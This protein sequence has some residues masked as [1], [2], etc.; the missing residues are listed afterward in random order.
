MVYYEEKVITDDIESED[1]I[2]IET[3]KLLK[4]RL[5]LKYGQYKSDEYEIKIIPNKKMCTTMIRCRLTRSE[6]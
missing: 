5:D 3:V 6:N 2:F 1:D 4:E